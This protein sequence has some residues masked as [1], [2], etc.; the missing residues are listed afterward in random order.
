MPEVKRD[1]EAKSSRVRASHMKDSDAEREAEKEAE[2]QAERDAADVEA[3]LSAHRGEQLLRGSDG[4][5]DH[6][7]YT[8]ACERE[9]AESD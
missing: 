5:F 6:V 1:D 7:A 3:F 4:S 9:R 8:V 2:D